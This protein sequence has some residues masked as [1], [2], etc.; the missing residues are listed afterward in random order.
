MGFLTAPVYIP[1]VPIL[2]E[3][4]NFNYPGMKLQTANIASAV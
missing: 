4:L 2:N 1:A 3:V